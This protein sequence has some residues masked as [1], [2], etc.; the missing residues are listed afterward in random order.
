MKPLVSV[1]VPVYNAEKYLVKCL[2][3]IINQTLKDIEIILVNDG[4]TDNSLKIIK[5]YKNKYKDKIVIIDK[6]N[7]GQGVARNEGM[8]VASGE[9]LTFID[10]DD[11]IDKNMLSDMVEVAHAK[12]ADIVYTSS[13]FEDTDYGVIDKRCVYTSEVIKNYILTQSGPCSKLIKREL[14]VKNNLYFPKLRAYEDI[15]V[16][17]IWAL[18][19]ENI[20]MLDKGYYYYLIHD[21]S[22]MKQISFNKKLYDIMDAMNNVYTEFLKKKKLDE[23]K[24]EIEWLYIC[25][26]LHA[27]SLRFFKFDN[28]RENIENINKIMNTKFPKWRNN[29]YYKNSNIKFRIVCNL[30]N[31]EQYFILKKVLR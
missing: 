25:H 26:L 13:M 6:K 30:I 11:Y 15:A 7:E 29:K 24:S 5:D 4:S 22:T 18:Y 23:Y 10:S 28:Y 14:I 27:A 2:D 21:G 3:S 9:Y 16:V 1:I 12:K 19:T 8:K 20:V 17:P 31:K